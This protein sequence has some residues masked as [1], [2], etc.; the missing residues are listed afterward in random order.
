[1]KTAYQEICMSLM[2]SA[3][4]FLLISVFGCSE[5]SSFK[6]TMILAELGYPHAQFDVGLAYQEGLLGLSKDYQKAAEWYLKAARQ[7]D[8]KSQ[9]NLGAL[10]D[11]GLGVGRDQSEAF[12]WYSLAA[13]QGQVSSYFNVAKLYSLGTGTKKDMEK[14]I[15]WYKKAAVQGD[16]KAQFNLGLIYN[17]GNGVPQDMRES[18]KWMVLAAQNSDKKAQENIE[19]VIKDYET[20]IA[21]LK[22]MKNAAEKWR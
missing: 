19:Q 10:Y 15:F 3:S 2:L 12:K 5:K 21:A 1:M 18:M 7:G 6:L 17:Q 20:N 22:W 14:A 13:E 16:V 4:V 8:A 11:K 9:V